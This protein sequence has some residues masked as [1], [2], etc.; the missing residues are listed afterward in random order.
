MSKELLSGGAAMKTVNLA[1]VGLP[2]IKL[3]GAHKLRRASP[4]LA[5]H[6]HPGHME[7]CYLAKGER[8]FHVNGTD[9]TLK[10]ND[11]FWTDSE[12]PH[13]SGFNADGKGLQYWIQLRVPKTPQRFLTLSAQDAWPLVRGL[14]SLPARCFP[15]TPR[16]KELYESAFRACERASKPVT[17]TER[18]SIATRMVEWLCAVVDCAHRKGPP[19]HSPPIREALA[20]L[21][22]QDELPSIAELAARV[23]LSESRFKARFRA[24]VGVPP[25]EYILRLR[26]RRASALLR[27][28]EKT[29][30]EIAY[31]LGFSSSQYFATTFKR[32]TNHSPSEVRDGALEATRRSS[33]STDVQLW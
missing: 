16:M 4:G 33:K 31:A 9:Y 14:R 24:E 1:D 22:N 17:P 6:R 5:M 25:G 18:L 7:I 20:W 32:F 26:I 13:G 19:P 28:T 15:G 29:V 3:M 27:E 21:E 10:G 11:V 8:V 12:E 2:E 23:H 30:T